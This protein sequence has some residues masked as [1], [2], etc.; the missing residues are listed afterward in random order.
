MRTGEESGPPLPRHERDISEPLP[1]GVG[2]RVDEPTPPEVDRKDIPASIKAELKSLPKDLAEVV[3]AH[4]MAA[5][6]LIEIDPELAYAHAEAAKRRAA[7][8]SIAREALAET[9]Y[10]AGRY[11]VALAEFR[12]LRRMTGSPD[13]LAVLADC[14]RALGKPEAALKL[15]KEGE[16]AVTDP[17]LLIEL[18]IVQA[19]A[20][21]DLGQRAEALRLLAD[22]IESPRGVVP[23]PSQARLRYAYAA[24]LLEQ[25]DT[26]A[27]Q[28][29][30]TAAARIDPDGT[31][32]L[33]RLD[34]LDGM[35]LITDFDE[36]DDEDGDEVEVEVEDDDE[37]DD[38]DDLDDAEDTED[39]EDSDSLGDSDE[40]EDTDDADGSEES[41]DSDEVEVL[42]NPDEAEP[43]DELAEEPESVVEPEML[44]DDMDLELPTE[45]DDIAEVLAEIDG[46][47]ALPGMETP[48]AE[49]VK[50]VRKPRTKD[51]ES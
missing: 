14:E 35:V 24:L 26:D 19:G 42:E 2:P 20:R 17:A 44:D 41:D 21:A 37:D 40:A 7:R 23:K 11:D 30:F 22:Q 25:G 43:V 5:I 51:T 9:A 6:E 50:R 28:Q 34:E 45:E 4:L 29:W 12:A 18:R 33:D 3:A 10:A 13:Y 32:A 16:Q 8:L 31:D 38:S 36:D 48:A 49:P 47:E 1:P 46:P 15:V 27:A 39:T